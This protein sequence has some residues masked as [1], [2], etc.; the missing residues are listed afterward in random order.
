MAASK[1]TRNNTASSKQQAACN[2]RQKRIPTASPV[3]LFV[4]TVYTR[5][6]YSQWKAQRIYSGC[7]ERRL[8]NGGHSLRLLLSATRPAGRDP[9]RPTSCS[10]NRHRGRGFACDACCKF[11]RFVACCRRLLHVACAPAGGAG[12]C[13]SAGSVLFCCMLQIRCCAGSVLI[14]C[15]FVCGILDVA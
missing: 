3:A 11:A 13:R 5:A 14:C 12:H 6:V 10:R 2:V 7:R 4:G 8:S 1:K 9:T 15:M